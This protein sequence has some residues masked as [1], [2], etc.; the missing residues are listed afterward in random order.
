MSDSPDTYFPRGHSASAGSGLQPLFAAGQKETEEKLYRLNRMVEALASSS[1]ALVRAADEAAYLQE[2][3]RIIVEDCGFKM[4]FIGFAQDD[5]AKSIHPA[6]YAGFEEGYLETL[7]LTWADTE[8]G[9]GAVGTAIRTGKVCQCRNVLTD[10]KVALWRED[11][12]RRGFASVASFPLLGS[13]G[14]AFGALNVYLTRSEGLSETEVRL[15]TELVGDCAQ[16]ISMLRLRAEKL[17]THANLRRSEEQFRTAFEDGAIAMT[18]TSST[19][20]SLLKVNFAFTRL[21]GYSEAELVGRSFVQITHPDDL[22]RNLAGWQMVANGEVP[23]FRMEKRFIRKDGSIVWGDM[24]TAGVRVDQGRP[25]YLITHVQDITERL[26]AEERLR[27]SEERLRLAQAGANAGVWDRDLRT[28]A[29][30]WTP[31]LA[32]LFG[33]EPGSVK[34]YDDFQ[35]LIH[36]DDVDIL[37]NAREAAVLNHEQFDAEFRI[38]RPNGE[39]RWVSARG[40]ALYDADGNPIRILGNNIDITE[41]KR[42]EKALADANKELLAA[43]TEL[44]IRNQQLAALT[45]QLRLTNEQLERGVVER[46][47]QLRALAGKLTQTEGRERRR[48]AKIVHDDLQQLLVGARMHLGAMRSHKSPESRR[49]SLEEAE[50]LIEESISVARNLS[51]DLSLVVLHEEGLNAALQSLARWMDQHYGLTVRIHS[52]AVTEPADENLNATLF[53]SVREL[54]FNVV[55]HAGVTHADVRLGLAPDDQIEILVSDAGKGFDPVQT[56]SGHAMRSAF[57]LFSIRERLQLLGGRMEMES[58]PGGGSQFRLYAPLH[59]TAR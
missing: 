21:L 2:V 38:I 37:E 16:G 31:E 17:D 29:L 54:L 47:A 43:G 42:A 28:G 41:R 23:S 14:K 53:Q 55:K 20:G 52:D 19:D 30:V 4:V 36:P 27:A 57:G 3:C 35:Q 39:L 59:D 6:S 33:L 8:R 18:L 26:R 7:N 32:V 12:L 51:H 48:I 1:R 50:Q 56:K 5:D 24:N 10:P 44:K 45:E 40:N 13:G 22:P 34:S 58:T 46:T 11:A 49:K 25:L 9:R 15:L